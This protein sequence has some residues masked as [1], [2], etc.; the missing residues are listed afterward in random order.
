MTNSGGMYLNIHLTYSLVVYFTRYCI[1]HDRK[2]EGVQKMCSGKNLLRRPTSGKMK[3][4]GYIY[5]LVCVHE[6]IACFIYLVS[7]D[8]I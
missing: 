4:Y 3:R 5:S 1:R 7:D 8:Y 6:L 2:R